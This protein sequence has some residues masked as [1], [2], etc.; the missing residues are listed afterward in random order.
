MTCL[1]QVLRWHL[2]LSCISVKHSVSN[3]VLFNF[4]NLQLRMLSWRPFWTLIGPIPM[5]FDKRCLISMS[6]D[7]KIRPQTKILWA[8]EVGFCITFPY[9]MMIL[10]Y[11]N[12]LYSNF[13]IWAILLKGIQSSFIWFRLISNLGSNCGQLWVSWI[14]TWSRMIKTF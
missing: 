1:C 4:L 10:W 7:L 12:P 13:V 11:L 14:Q 9:L 5:A 8:L 3:F 2:F 6:S